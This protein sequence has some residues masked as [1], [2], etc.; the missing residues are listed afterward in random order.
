MEKEK[1]SCYHQFIATALAHEMNAYFE[2]SKQMKEY[3]SQKD[4]RGNPPPYTDSDQLR[5]NELRLKI[6][7]LTASYVE[8]LANN[9]LS[10]KLDDSEFEAVENVEAL[11]KWVALP[12][13]FL[14]GYKFPKDRVIYD[15]LKMLIGQRNLIVH[16]KPR[17]SV[18]DKV[19]KKGN[20]PKK[21]NIHNY[22]QKWDKLP[23]E[24]IEFLGKYDSSHEFQKFRALT[25]IDD[26]QIIRRG[27]QPSRVDNS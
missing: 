19:V 3:F 16:M 9:Y 25:F 27:C 11:K 24:L 18:G 14:Q 7:L 13:V 8:A 26:Y 22:I 10:I 1:F 17:I 21:F 6:I 2:H 20:L 5:T 23:G 15:S 12:G 4:S